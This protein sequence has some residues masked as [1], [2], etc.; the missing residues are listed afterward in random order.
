M[1]DIVA[2][3]DGEDM[4]MLSTQTSKAENI[5]NI[6]LGSLTYAPELGIDLEYF[7]QPGI[8]FQTASFKA[9]LVETLANRGVNVASTEEQIETLFTNLNINLSPV[10]ESTGLI[11]G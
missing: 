5:L 9:Y 11:V 3:P 1:I 6:Q 7:L 4:R 10:E 8:R 2:F